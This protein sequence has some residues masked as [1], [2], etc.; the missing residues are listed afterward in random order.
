M[1][2]EDIMLSEINQSQKD[3]YQMMIPLKMY[4]EES[5]SWKQKV[6]LWLSEYGLWG[7]RLGKYHLMY[8][9]FQF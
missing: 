6:E 9:E 1:N 7:G 4:L 2:L 3:K 5:Q 8:T